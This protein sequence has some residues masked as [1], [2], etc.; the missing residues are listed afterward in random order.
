MTYY[1]VKMLEKFVVETTYFVQ[2]A[3]KQEAERMITDG[4][5]AYSALSPTDDP[6]EVL[7]CL[8]SCRVSKSEVPLT[9][10]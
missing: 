10:Q 7:K 1:K 4:E 5:V 9:D 2:A 6:G 8:S 3:N